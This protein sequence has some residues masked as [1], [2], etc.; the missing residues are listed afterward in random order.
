MAA[1]SVGT[2]SPEAEAIMA[3]G[4]AELVVI[5]RAAVITMAA[6]TTV[7]VVITGTA[8]TSKLSQR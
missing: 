3:V 8:P 4:G 1:G 2:R 7:V 5:R 6:V